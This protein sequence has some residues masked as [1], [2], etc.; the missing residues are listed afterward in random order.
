M[1]PEAAGRLLGLLRAGEQSAM[2]TFGRLSRRLSA[3]SE[4]RARQALL[5]LEADECRHDL[6]LATTAASMGISAVRPAARVRHFFLKMESRELAVHLARV[7]ALDSCVCQLLARVLSPKQGAKLPAI[8]AQ[9]LTQI[10]RDEGR[11]VRVARAL[12]LD[13]GVGAAV[14]H[15]QNDATRYAFAQ[16]IDQYEPA[17]IDLGVAFEPLRQRI[18]RD[19]SL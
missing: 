7:A 16:V 1:N 4:A 18:A 6:L 10:Q 14:L 17:F 12:A 8:L 13:L 9:A 15:E 2:L 3:A 11:H 19:A 5:E